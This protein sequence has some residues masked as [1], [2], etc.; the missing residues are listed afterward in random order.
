MSWTY[1]PELPE[2]SG[3]YQISYVEPRLTLV[4]S[5]RFDPVMTPR[6]TEGQFRPEMPPGFQWW[7]DNG[8]LRKVYA[9]KPIDEVAEV[10]GAAL[11][12]LEREG[13]R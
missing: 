7:G 8:Y 6:R 4:S 13:G 12:Y 10:T 9:W 3:P 5:G 2:V 1:L 11:A